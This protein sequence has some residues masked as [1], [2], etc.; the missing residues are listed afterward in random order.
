M[1]LKNLAKRS[2]LTYPSL[3]K[4][5]TDYVSNGRDQLYMNGNNLRLHYVELANQT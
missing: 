5:M 1:G 2:S 3:P 4:Q